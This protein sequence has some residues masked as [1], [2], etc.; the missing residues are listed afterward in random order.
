MLEADARIRQCQIACNDEEFGEMLESGPDVVVADQTILNNSVIP[1]PSKL[2]LIHDQSAF[3]VN[4]KNL[5]DLISRG[6]A[7]VL[8]SNTD[9]QMLRKAIGA[10]AAGQLW[11]DHNTIDHMLCEGANSE[12]TFALTD[13][14]SEVLHYLCAGLSNREIAEKLFISEQTIKSHCNHLYRKFGV[15]N[16]VKLMVYVSEHSGLS[17]WSPET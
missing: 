6:L 12:K 16:R 1:P 17:K 14:E 10:V 13:R 4:S 5:Q 7:G 11:L 8:V 2:L 3:S 15:Q 9:S